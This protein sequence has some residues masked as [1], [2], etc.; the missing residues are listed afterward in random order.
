[1]TPAAG[2]TPLVSIPPASDTILVRRLLDESLALFAAGRNDDVRVA[3][4]SS[5]P[6]ARGL[7][8]SSAVGVALLRAVACA[9][10][11]SLAPAE[12]ARLSAAFSRA[13]GLSATGAFDDAM[14]AAAG[15]LV[16]TRN[17]PDEVLLD[18]LVDPDWRAALWVPD[19]AHDP[20][21]LWLDAFRAR[22][23]DGQLAAEMAQ[24]GEYL[25][26]MR[27]NTELVERVVGYE[28]GPLRAELARRGA[29][30]SGVS[31]MGPALAAI[32]PSG[33]IAEVARGYPVGVG[34]VLTVDFVRP[35]RAERTMGA[36]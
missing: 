7:K 12:A 10:G 2:P 25:A 8:S 33:R 29:L 11:R 36:P 14:A 20:S 28:Y 32:A 23:A 9:V 19:A 18:G 6:V 27:S 26:A 13:H 5:I 15:G 16:V 21:P 24:R 22:A 34:Q 4:R 3:V 30:G 1:M 35:G 17:G 31:G